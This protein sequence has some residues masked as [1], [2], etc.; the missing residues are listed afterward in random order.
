MD[1]KTESGLVRLNCKQYLLT[2]LYRGLSSQRV[3]A[4]TDNDL[5]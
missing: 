5:E 2:S 3:G 1:A 4:A